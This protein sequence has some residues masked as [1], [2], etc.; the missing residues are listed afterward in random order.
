MKK[1][2]CML[3]CLLLILPVFAACAN[4]KDD[5]DGSTTTAN[6]G[7]STTTEEEGTKDAVEEALKLIDVDYNKKTFEILTRKDVG[8]SVKELKQDSTSSEP[9]ENAVYMRNT[10]LAE[11]CNL[12]YLVTANDNVVSAVKNQV[13]SG[14]SDVAL[15]FPN[16]I[17]AGTLASDGQ[18]NDFNSL[19]GLNLDGEWWD[20]GTRQL[21]L[22]GGV[23]FMNS[24]VNYMAHDVTF[25]VLFSKKMAESKN[26]TDMYSLVSNNEWTLDKMISLMSDVAKDV[27]NDGIADKD[28]IYG[29]IATAGLG[30]A[31]FYGS[32]LQY[33]DASGDSLELAIGANEKQKIS[34]LLDKIHSFV[35]TG[36][37]TWVSKQGEE[38][39][40]QEMFSANKS[41]FYAE[42]AS[43]IVNLRKMAD[44]FGV[45]PLPKYDASQEN[46]L[47][48]VHNISSTMTVPK[49][50]SE[51]NQE[52]VSAV[53]ETMVLLSKKYVR[54]AYYDI[55]LA[56]KGVR[57]ENS[58]EMLDIIF[59]HR[60]YDLAQY[61]SYFKMADIFNQCVSNNK[62]FESAFASPSKNFKS[63]VN[64]VLRKLKR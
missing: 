30:S 39:V 7:S 35:G 60:V 3:L 43:Y 50:V 56:S 25:L 1:T 36:N 17:D 32:G 29:L 21:Q 40:G 63:N 33:I 38:I 12:V 44:N 45:L 18:S 28:D 23:Y 51:E 26:L 46:Y 4:Q 42:V 58:A 41:L 55:T 34:T 61:Y 14:G 6:S 15:A 10:E 27:N 9:L 64:K 31:L 19:D 20:Q 2:L 57:D 59:A 13:S 48:Y 8:N 16:M 11:R 49:T 37:T 62:G 53:I 5:N 54:S 52:D 24:D 22:N 47:T